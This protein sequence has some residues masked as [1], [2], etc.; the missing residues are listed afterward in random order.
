[1]THPRSVLITGASSGIG[2]ALALAYA[3]PGMRLTLVARRE[4]ALEGVA[5]ECRRRGAE[6][7]VLACDVTDADRLGPLM[8]SADDVHPI[9]LVIANAGISG[10]T[11]DGVEPEAQ[12]R[13]IVTVNLLGTITTVYALLP[14]MMGRGRGQIAIVSSLAGFRG[15][16]SAPAYAA[17]KAAQRV[18]GDGLRGSLAGSGVGVSVVC[19]GFVKTPLTDIN[20]YRMPMI[21]SAQDAAALIKRRLAAGAPLIAFPWPLHL[22]MRILAALPTRLADWLLSF[23]PKKGGAAQGGD[24][25]GARDHK[26]PGASP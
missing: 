3:A 18:L 21:M 11:A 15:M 2:E 1:M 24:E 6:A 10:G 23:A 19:P 16:A 9:D 8:R 20:T 14:A 13:N 7:I 4:E 12:V 26:Q 22:L 5:T 25:G 17:S